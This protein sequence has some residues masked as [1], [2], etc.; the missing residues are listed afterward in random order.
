MLPVGRNFAPIKIYELWYEA[1]GS[2]VLGI[3][4]A[5]VRDLV[6][7]LRDVSNRD[8]A[9]NPLISGTGKITHTLAFGVSQSGRFLRHFLELGMNV[10][11]SGQKV[12]DGV[13]SHVAGAGKVFANH[14]FAMPGRT[15]TEHEDRLYPENW[16]PFSTA[17][18]A[19]PVSGRIAALFS[20]TANDPKIIETNSATEYWQKGASLIHTDPGLRRDLK[21]PDKSRVYLIAG[22]QHGGR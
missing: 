10:D 22:T 13:F 9:P 6:S 19:D 1:T 17:K 2:K 3:G 5:A 7:F 12:F 8:D 4:Y 20:G 11:E 15:A 21:L 18:T 14:S 16:F